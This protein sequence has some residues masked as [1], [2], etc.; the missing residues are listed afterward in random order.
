PSAP[1]LSHDPR[2][3][4]LSGLLL[5]PCHHVS[6]LCDN[7]PQLLLSPQHPP[8]S[9]RNCHRWTEVP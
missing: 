8:A 4:P 2:I 6:R 5:L 7:V 1:S 9:P 3:P